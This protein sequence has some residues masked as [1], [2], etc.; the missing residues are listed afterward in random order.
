VPGTDINEKVDVAV[1]SRFPAC[2]RPD[3]ALLTVFPIQMLIVLTSY[4]LACP[5]SHAHGVP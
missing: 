4:R 2:H 3:V 1:W 5:L